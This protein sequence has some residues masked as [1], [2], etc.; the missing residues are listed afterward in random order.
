LIFAWVEDLLGALEVL[1]LL[2]GMK[3]GEGVGKH[4][5]S[6]GMLYDILFFQFLSALLE[7]L[8]VIRKL[9]VLL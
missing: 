8:V 6:F 4:A 1:V 5:P 9:V 2:D 3:L 7:L